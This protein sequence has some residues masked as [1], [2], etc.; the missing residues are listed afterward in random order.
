MEDQHQRINNSKKIMEA[1]Q[2]KSVDNL[3]II[4]NLLMYYFFQVSNTPSF[5]QNVMPTVF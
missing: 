1:N 2:H 5:Y 4:I 3:R